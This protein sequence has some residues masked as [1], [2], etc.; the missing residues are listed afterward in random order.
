MVTRSLNYRQAVLVGRVWCD[1][2]SRG[3]PV[4][5]SWLCEAGWLRYSQIA[6]DYSK[7]WFRTPGAQSRNYSKWLADSVWEVD[8]VHP[9][10][11]LLVDLLP[12]LIGNFEG[13]EQRQ[14]VLEVGLFWQAGHDD[15]ME[16][17]IN[18]RQ[19]PD[20]LRGAPSYRSSF[21]AYRWGDAK[22]FRTQSARFQS[23]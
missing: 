5:R 21:N 17:N 11:A 14:F 19:T 22:S 13:W 18:S 1:Q 12:D 10:Q 23:N 3:A 9:N 20:I 7:Y 6:D 15:G 4:V 16:F 2:L 8:T